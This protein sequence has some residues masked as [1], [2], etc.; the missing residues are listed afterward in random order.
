MEV[1]ASDGRVYIPKRL[2]EE[3][4]DRFELV[5][6]GDRLVLI[7]IAADPLEALREEFEDVDKSVEELEE[8]ALEEAL[9][10]AGS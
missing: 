2:R 7:P 9:R 10:Q 4:G 1:D 3:F 6:R 8:D 5:D